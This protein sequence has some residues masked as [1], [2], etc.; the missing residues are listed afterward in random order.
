[1]LSPGKKP[2]TYKAADRLKTVEK[3]IEDENDDEDDLGRESFQ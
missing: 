3:Q 1:L 2:E